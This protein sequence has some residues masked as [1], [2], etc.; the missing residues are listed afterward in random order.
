MLDEA[1]LKQARRHA[2]RAGVALV[3]SVV[4]EGLLTDGALAEMLVRRLHLTR[5]DLAHEP[6][7]DDAIRE[8]PHDF[9]DAHRLLPLTIDRQA[10]RRVVRVAMADPLDLDAV[11]E[12]EL[13]T[14]CDVE[15]LIAPV[16]ELADAIQR[17]YRGVITKMIPR[18]PLF[19]Q[20]SAK[21]EGLRHTPVVPHLEPSTQPTHQLANEASLELKLDALIELLAVT[22][23]I[24]REAW[25]AAVRQL[26]KTDADE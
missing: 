5:V 16:K 9:A 13:S 23:V 6:V 12:I 19:G 20:A 4:D 21:G 22:G 11:E 2:R 17:Y 10:Q 26:L 8:V 25:E 14:G 3:R 18:R 7:D 15:P 24:E 1:A